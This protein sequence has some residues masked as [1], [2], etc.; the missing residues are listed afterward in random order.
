MGRSLPKY[1][2]YLQKLEH[3]A[4]ASAVEIVRKEYDS[5]GA[6]IPQYRTIILDKDLE[7]SSEIAVLL[8][9]LG[10]QLDDAFQ[11]KTIEKNLDRAYK[12]AYNKTP[13]EAQLQLVVDCEARAWECGRAIAKKL[14][15]KLG[16][17]YD[18]E[19]TSAMDFYRS[20]KTR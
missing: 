1:D 8:H 17:W 14:R 6:Y 2:D 20:I 19:V 9:E 16:K 15:I 7:E 13:T 11:N 12:A 5:D 3:Y 18:K 4:E 10:H